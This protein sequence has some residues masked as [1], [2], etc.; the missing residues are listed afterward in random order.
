MMR[1]HN[2]CQ[3]AVSSGSLAGFGFRVA[4]RFLTA[5]VFWLLLL[6]QA[7]GAPAAETFTGQ[8]S[9]PIELRIDNVELNK[10]IY[11]L[12]IRK[13]DVGYLLSFVSNGTVQATVRGRR[14]EDDLLELS[15]KLP[16]MGTQYLRSSLEPT[17]TAQERQ[18]SKTGQPQYA[19]E[20]RNWKATLRTYRNP[21]TGAVVFVFYLAENGGK[22]KRIDFVL[23]SGSSTEPK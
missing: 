13:E 1:P 16:V 4:L 11:D 22:W 6:D 7:H 9:I 2:P 23:S 18:F 21:N 5:A 8:V 3:L 10:G 20:S 15:A 19:E 14:V 12:A 17:R